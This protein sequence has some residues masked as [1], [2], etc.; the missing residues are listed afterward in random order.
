MP[1]APPLRLAACACCVLVL[2][3]ACDKAPPPFHQVNGAWHYHDVP[4]AG[5]DAVSFTVLSEHY[6]KDRAHV[7]YGDRYREGREYYAIAHDR[8]AALRDADPAT[9][10]YI[11]REYGKDATHVWFEGGRYAVQEAASFEL[12]DYAFARDRTSGYCYLAPVP[13]SDGPT[14]AAVDD[15]YA[16]DRARAYHCSLETDGGSHAPVATVV[17][18]AQAQPATLKSLER[19][20]AADGARVWYRGTLVDDADVASFEVLP[21]GHGDAD[22]RDARGTFVMGKRVPKAP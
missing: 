16:K 12:L 22:A 8:V 7:Y 6:A 19:G 5:A 3:A 9:F 21:V 1:S 17:P 13:G 2:V 4:V 14:F 11:A 18:L 10:R 15:H 20:Y